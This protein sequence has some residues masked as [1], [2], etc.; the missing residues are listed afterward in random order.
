MRLLFF[1]WLIV[2]RALSALLK[3]VFNMPVLEWDNTINHWVE[4]GANYQQASLGSNVTMTTANTYYDGPQVTIGPF[5]DQT[6]W[7]V[8]G[9]VVVG[10]SGVV[11]RS[12]GKLWDGTTVLD[13]GE[14]QINSGSVVGPADMPFYGIYTLP[15]NTTAT[16]KISATS[17]TASETLYATCPDNA[18]GA[19][20]A[21]ILAM[22]ID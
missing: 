14:D 6:V 5:P 8:C 2:L 16:L 7:Y 1:A 11:G 15:A 4:I 17:T 20:A 21:K 19:T 9:S 3:S 22:R 13:S 18:A 10:G 12:T